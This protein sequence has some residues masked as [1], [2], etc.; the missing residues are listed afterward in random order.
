MR[1]GREEREKN[2]YTTMM[3]REELGDKRCNNEER[4]NLD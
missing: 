2:N 1:G 4:D 3:E